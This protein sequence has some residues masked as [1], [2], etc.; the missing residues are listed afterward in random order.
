MQD[1]VPLTMG[2]VFSGYHAQLTLALEQLDA[3]MPMLALAI[4]ATAV[5]TGLNSPSTF[6]EDVSAK[7]S[8]LI[9]QPFVTAPNKYQA[10][11][12]H[13]AALALSGCLKNL[14]ASLYKIANDVRMLA[15]GPRCGLGELVLPKNEPGS[16]IMPGKVN[17][18]QCEALCMVA[19]QVFACDHANFCRLQGHFELN[20]PVIAHNILQA[21]D[22]LSDLWKVLWTTA[23]AV[24]M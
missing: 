13:N 8:G 6:G 1:A 16:S 11:S 22:L 5:C 9:G 3:C 12:A 21:L 2:H 15:S 7:F 24:L 20:K 10:L 14:A 19:I 4:G 23:C 17:P 18:T